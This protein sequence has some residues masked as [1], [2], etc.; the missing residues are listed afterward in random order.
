MSQRKHITIRPR[1]NSALE[2]VYDNRRKELA[3]LVHQWAEAEETKATQ[4]NTKREE[5]DEPF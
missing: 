1:V 5:K 3:G 4:A 2:R